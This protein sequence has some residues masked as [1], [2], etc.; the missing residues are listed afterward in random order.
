[1]LSKTHASWNMQP[2]FSLQQAPHERWCANEVVKALKWQAKKTSE[3]QKMW[4]VGLCCFRNQEVWNDSTWWLMTQVQEIIGR[5]VDNMYLSF[6]D[7]GSQ[8]SSSC[9]APVL[10]AFCLWIASTVA[11]KPSSFNRIH[12]SSFME[13]TCHPDRYIFVQQECKWK[14]YSPRQIAR[15]VWSLVW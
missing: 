14:S 1:M 5:I 3:V 15:S 4:V 9:I 7:G 10:V 13:K 12:T 2:Q 6:A 11:T 8:K